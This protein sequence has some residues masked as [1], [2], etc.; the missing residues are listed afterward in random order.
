MRRQDRFHRLWWRRPR[1]VADCD[2]FRGRQAISLDLGMR[3]SP[4]GRN[5]TRTG[6]RLARTP[7]AA[8]L[9]GRRPAGRPR[10]GAELSIPA[11][12]H[13]HAGGARRPGR[14]AGPAAALGAALGRPVV[15]DDRP[16]AGGTLAWNTP[17]GSA[18]TATP[19]SSPAAAPIP[20][21]RISI[22]CLTTMTAPSPRSPCSPGAQ[23]AH[24]AP[25]GADAQ[26]G[27]AGRAGP[28]PARWPHLRH[29]RHR[30]HQP[31]GDRAVHGADR[32]VAAAC[33]PSRR[34]AGDP[35]AAGRRSGPQLHGSGLRPQPAR[36]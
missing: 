20:S 35:G 33:A 21:R 3:Q 36:H 15:I 31:P 8:S 26:R 17:P 22:R 16:G 5:A 30:L 12:H 24:P 34:R 2:T 19:S 25:H 13:H 18:P 14:H 27:G 11:H 6:A 23:L 1:S 29:R 9:R 28:R 4:P 7:F 10:P 32:G